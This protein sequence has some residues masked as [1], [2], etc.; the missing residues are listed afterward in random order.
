MIAVIVPLCKATVRTF[1]TRQTRQK[2]IGAA[3]WLVALGPRCGILSFLVVSVRLWVHGM[4]NARPFIESFLLLPQRES[5]SGF[6]PFILQFFKRFNGLL[7]LQECDL[8]LLKFLTQL[9][10][11]V[12]N[13]GGLSG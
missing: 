11:V 12:G 5:L 1:P 4:L 3:T 10:L 8:T 13:L 2:R 7:T 9:P 6:V